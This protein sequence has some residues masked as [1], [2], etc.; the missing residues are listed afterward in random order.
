M[1]T[2]KTFQIENSKHTLGFDQ[3]LKKQQH[4]VY[5]LLL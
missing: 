4:K 3:A 2:D 1:H 5:F